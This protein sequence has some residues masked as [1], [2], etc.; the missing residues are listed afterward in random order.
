MNSRILFFLTLGA[1]VA[2]CDAP[3]AVPA[4]S[5]STTRVSF[6]ALVNS[7]CGGQTELT[8]SR[9]S[10]SF[11]SLSSLASASG[12]TG[13][14]TSPYIGGSE[15]VHAKIF[16]HDAIC[17]R[18][19]DVVFDPDKDRFRPA[20]KLVVYF[21][22]N[23]GIGLSSTGVNVGSSITFSALMQLG[24]DVTWDLT[25][26]VGR[27]AKIDAK[28]PGAPRSLEYPA[29]IAD[30]PG[31]PTGG[32]P[33]PKFRIALGISGCETL[34]YALIRSTRDGGLDGFEQLVGQYGSDGSPLGQWSAARNGTWTVESVDTGA[35]HAAQCYVTKKG[36]LVANGSPMNMP[37]KVSIA[38]L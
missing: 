37:F 3:T 33:T 11:A 4:R 7:E 18:S 16:Y 32:I 22:A 6:A 12:I 21:P 35:G 13:D 19:G 10:L 20:R 38:E 24:S 26:E 9:A 23:N 29:A 17:S 27:D 25:N 2:A 30:R 28:I 36:S 5:D 1:V 14:G 31:Y 15:G 34:E 8:D